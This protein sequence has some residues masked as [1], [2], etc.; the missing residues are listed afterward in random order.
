MTDFPGLIHCLVDQNVEFIIVGGAVATLHGASR[1]TEDLD[2][3]Y[4][5]DPAN[6]ASLVEALQ[7]LHPYPRGAP[8]GLPFRFDFRTL[9]NGLNFTLITDAGSLDLLGEI[10]G[11]G[12][13]RDLLPFSREVRIYGRT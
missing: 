10:T 6:L 2:I 13:Y 5:R 3:V 9:Q 1:L 4:D 8:P 7:P 12:G 11:G